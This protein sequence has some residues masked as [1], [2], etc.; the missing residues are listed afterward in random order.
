MGD[1]DCSTPAHCLLWIEGHP[2]LVGLIM[3]EDAHKA[4]H[5]SNF[6]TPSRPAIYNGNIPTDASNSVRV[7]CKASQTTKKEDYRLFAAAEHDSK[8]F[9]LAVVED[10]W[11]R[12]LCD[13]DIFYTSVNPRDLL[14]HLQAMCVGLYATDVLNLQNDMQTYHEDMEG[15]T[16]YIN[17]LEDAHKQSTRAGNLITEPTLLLFAANAMLRTDRFPRSNYIWEE[18]PGANR[19]CK[20]CKAIYRKAI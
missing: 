16:K 5:G 1:P 7:R 9:I 19:T 15:I 17:K 2:N 4:Y 12:E 3:D 13:P 6:P 11:V 10:M 20:R 8:K 14:K 18:L